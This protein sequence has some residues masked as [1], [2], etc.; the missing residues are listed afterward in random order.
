ML[1]ADLL[2]GALEF[3]DS[4]RFNDEVFEGT[5]FDGAC[6]SFAL[7]DFCRFDIVASAF[8]RRTPAP[9]LLPVPDKAESLC[10]RALVRSVIIGRRKLTTKRQWGTRMR[11]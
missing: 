10:S 1:E 6:G 4:F 8:G 9:S 11:L 5:D 7:V 2:G 3:A